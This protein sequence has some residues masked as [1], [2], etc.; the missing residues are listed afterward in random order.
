LIIAV[1]GTL[2]V[3]LLGNAGF[4]VVSALGGLVSSAS[5]T[6]SA[7]T[8]VMDGKLTPLVA[9]VATVLTSAISALVRLP[10]VHQQT[11]SRELTWKLGMGTAAMIAFGLAGSFGMWWLHP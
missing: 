6:A 1:V 7:A 5:T 10:L 9:G 11:R 4:L 8:L 3:R 2:A